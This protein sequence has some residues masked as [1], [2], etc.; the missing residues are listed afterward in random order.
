MIRVITELR[1]SCPSLFLSDDTQF[2][3]AGVGFI[4]STFE[5]NQ[6]EITCHGLP[7]KQE[8]TLCGV[9]E[10]VSKGEG[11][12][13]MPGFS[14]EADFDTSLLDH[15]IGHVFVLPREVGDASEGE[16]FSEIYSE[17]VGMF[18]WRLIPACVPEGFGV[19]ID[20]FGC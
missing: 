19:A 1:P 10:E 13:V 3:G 16:F 11:A 8:S 6:A 20:R 9:V 4:L 7:L 17:C 2:C 12:G 18:G 15:A 5:G 14:V